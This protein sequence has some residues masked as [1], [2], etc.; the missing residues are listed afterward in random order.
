MTLERF[1]FSPVIFVRAFFMAG[2]AVTAPRSPSSSGFIPPYS[3]R[4]TTM[5]KFTTGVAYSASAGS[6][7]HGVLTYFSPDEW[8]AVGVLVGISIA[9]V[10]CITNWYYRRK[11]TLAEI[12][13]LHCTCKEEPR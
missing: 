13:A 1:L 9:T 10:T 12:R 2:C 4:Q 7:L 6:V 3:A 5:S 8:S 11:A